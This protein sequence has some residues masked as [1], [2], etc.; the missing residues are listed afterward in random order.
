VAVTVVAI[1]SPE[2]AVVV[3]YGLGFSQMAMQCRE[4]GIMADF[5][6]KDFL[7]YVA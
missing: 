6:Y 2:L 7:V 4:M 5:F 1:G 3:Y